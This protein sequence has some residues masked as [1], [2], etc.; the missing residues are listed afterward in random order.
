MRFYNRENEIAEL[1][2]IRNLSFPHKSRMWE[3]GMA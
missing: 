3:M 2:R 1:R